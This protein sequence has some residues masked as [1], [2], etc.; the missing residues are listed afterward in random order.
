[1]SSLL[2][3]DSSF[4]I[5]HVLGGAKT[6]SSSVVVAVVLG[7]DGGDTFDVTIG[8]VVEKVVSVDI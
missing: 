4:F 1:M 5:I 6:S 7:S 3:S 8:D 2:P